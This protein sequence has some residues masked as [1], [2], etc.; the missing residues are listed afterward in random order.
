MNKVCP[1]VTFTIQSYEYQCIWGNETYIWNH[2]SINP[3]F[4]KLSP[5]KTDLLTA[6][7]RQTHL[8]PHSSLNYSSIEVLLYCGYTVFYTLKQGKLPQLSVWRHPIHLLETQAMHNFSQLSK[9]RHEKKALATSVIKTRGPYL[10]SW[11]AR[12]AH[13][14]PNF[15]SYKVSRAPAEFCTGELLYAANRKDKN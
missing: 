12:P 3:S 1:V 10:Y 8:E 6:Y 9:T 13:W 7:L 4:K 11:S 2:R 14:H 15:S 5:V